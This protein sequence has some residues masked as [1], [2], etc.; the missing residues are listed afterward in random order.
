[1]EYPFRYC[2]AP[3]RCEFNH[4]VFQVNDET[5]LDHDAPRP[6]HPSPM[7]EAYKAELLAAVR[8]RPRSSGLPF[9]L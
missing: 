8:R 7:T 4:L 6:G 9:A 5:P 1:M 3:L 2:K